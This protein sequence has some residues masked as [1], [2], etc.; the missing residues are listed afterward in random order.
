MASFI[1]ANLDKPKTGR[2]LAR[3]FS[4]GVHCRAPNCK[5]PLTIYQ[6][7]GAELYC[8]RHQR[9]LAPYGGLAVADKPHTF[10]RTAQCEECGYDAN[11]D[12][13]ISALNDEVLRNLV[14]RTVMTGD[15]IDG[16][17]SNDSAENL[18]CLCARCHAV[19]TAINGDNLT[20]AKK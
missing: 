8:R 5:R 15:H 12:P 18:Q 10:V 13:R 6:G 11:Q 7:P 14:T 17:H 20:P 4:A 2:A 1:N 16:T 3:V 9:E 19:K